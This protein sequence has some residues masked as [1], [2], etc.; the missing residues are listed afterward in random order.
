M[1]PYEELSCK[2]WSMW[3]NHVPQN[4]LFRKRQVIIIKPWPC[5]DSRIFLFLTVL[6]T[7]HK[8]PCLLAVLICKWSNKKQRRGSIFQISQKERLFHLLYHPYDNLAMWS[9]FLHPSKR[10]FSLL[11]FGQEG[12]TDLFWKL[13]GCSLFPQVE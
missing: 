7:N 6:S 5:A 2:A 8:T 11:Q 12:F 13:P 1:E 4:I 10:P 9:P 3:Q